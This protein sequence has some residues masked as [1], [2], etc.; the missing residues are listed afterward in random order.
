MIIIKRKTEAK[1]LCILDLQF[2]RAVKI[3]EKYWDA[4]P[5]LVCMTCC[6]IGHE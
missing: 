5:G 3:V 2:G 1:K 6:G 4:G